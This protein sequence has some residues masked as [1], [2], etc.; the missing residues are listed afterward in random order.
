MLLAMFWQIEKARTL[1]LAVR[2]SS[3]TN[4]HIACTMRKPL[5]V[6]LTHPVTLTLML[7]RLCHQSVRFVI[8]KRQRIENLANLCRPYS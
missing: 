3:G 7:H 2:K 4:L 1:N 5:A 8:I 6:L